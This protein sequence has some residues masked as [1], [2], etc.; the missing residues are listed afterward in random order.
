MNPGPQYQNEFFSFMNWNLNSLPKNDFE[1]AQLIEAHNSIFNYDIISLCE[2]SLNDKIKVPD[3]LLNDYTFL[4]AKNPNNETHG[5]VGLFYKNSLPL[6]VRNDLSFN[7]TIVVELNFGRKKVFFTVLYRSPSIKHSTPEFKDFKN[8]F[9]NLY[10]KIQVER[11][12]ASFFTGDFNGHSK[13]WWA[14]GDDTPEGKEIEEMFTL[15]NL[16]QIISEPTNF[17][18]GKNPS[19]IDLIVTDQPNLILESGTRPSLD[20]IIFSKINF[21]IPP[22]PQMSRRI[23]H[24]NQANSECIKRS[25][26]R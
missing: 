10:S 26:E 21:K 25:M 7:E 17:T 18:P 22:P 8:N 6:I 16:S 24:Y 1:R 20:Q 19:C 3:P 9:Q 12:F 15:L 5:G 11:P 14:E 23:W 2:I 13:Y 4:S